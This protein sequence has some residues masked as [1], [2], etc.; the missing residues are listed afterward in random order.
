MYGHPGGWNHYHVCWPRNLEKIFRPP[1]L[2][3]T[4]REFPAD[5]LQL[6]NVLHLDPPSPLRSDIERDGESDMIQIQTL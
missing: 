4:G 6:S 2:T 3:K 1:P 5:F